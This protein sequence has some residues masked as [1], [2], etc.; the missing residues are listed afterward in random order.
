MNLE[1]AYKLKIIIY[2][3]ASKSSVHSDATISS[4]SMDHTVPTNCFGVGRCNNGSSIWNAGCESM[5]DCNLWTDFFRY[6]MRFEQHSGHMRSGNHKSVNIHTHVNIKKFTN[7]LSIWATTYHFQGFAEL[8]HAHHV[9]HGRRLRKFSTRCSQVCLLLPKQKGK[10]RYCMGVKYALLPLQT[11]PYSSQSEHTGK[12]TPSARLAKKKRV[13]S[14]RT[15]VSKVVSV[16]L[17]SF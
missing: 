7:T 9:F 14:L 5:P 3:T 1:H 8:K 12:T 15:F 10:A 13:Q 16:S 17:Q 6:G 11:N 4:S 2:I